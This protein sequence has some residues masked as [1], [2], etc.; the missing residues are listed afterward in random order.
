MARDHLDNQGG[1]AFTV[2]NGTGLQV[3]TKLQKVIDALRTLSEGINK[4]M[5]PNKSI[6]INI[7]NLKS[8]LITVPC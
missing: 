2:D 3:R 1:V 6:I 5:N 4:I 8:Y 7:R